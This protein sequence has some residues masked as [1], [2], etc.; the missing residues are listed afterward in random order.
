MSNMRID[1][2]GTSQDLT[3]RVRKFVD[4]CW[5]S[6]AGGELLDNYTAPHAVYHQ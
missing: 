3:L 4:G 1:W 5:R 6:E 2:I